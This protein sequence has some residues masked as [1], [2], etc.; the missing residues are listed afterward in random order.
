MCDN[1]GVAGLWW[2]DEDADYIRRRS[3]RYPGALNIEPEWT[4]EAAADPRAIVRDPESEEPHRRDPTDRLLTGCGVGPHGDRGPGRL[5]RDH[6][7]EGAR[8]DLRSYLEG[9]AV[10]DD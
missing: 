3:D 7:E 10:S 2:D 6:R 1:V 5:G 9:E 4:L 8:A